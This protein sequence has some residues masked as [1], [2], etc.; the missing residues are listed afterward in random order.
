[1]SGAADMR[2]VGNEI[3]KRH[4]T[5]QWTQLNSDLDALCWSQLIVP[6]RNR[7]GTTLNQVFFTTCEES[8]GMGRVGTVI[9][10]LLR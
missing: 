1:M 4:S 5:S 3:R 6:V 8:K 9:S 10:S 7:V 2:D